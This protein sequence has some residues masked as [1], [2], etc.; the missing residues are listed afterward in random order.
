MFQHTAK[1]GVESVRQITWEEPPDDIDQIWLTWDIVVS[2]SEIVS[3]VENFYGQ[4]YASHAYR[5]DS[6]S[7]KICQKSANV[8]SRRLLDSLRMENPRVRMS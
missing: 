4:L 6:I 8:K 2:K 7:Q 3:E 1:P 5:P